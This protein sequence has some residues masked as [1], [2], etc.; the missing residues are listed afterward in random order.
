MSTST[1]PT[2]G[3]ISAAVKPFKPQ[4]ASIDSAYL[5]ESTTEVSEAKTVATKIDTASNSD[6]S[7]SE[8][9]GDVVKA[10]TTLREEVAKL[11]GDSLK[12]LAT[13]LEGT[14]ALTARVQGLESDNV[15]K[16]YQ[17]EQLIKANEMPRILGSDTAQNPFVIYVTYR[18]LYPGLLQIISQRLIMH[19]SR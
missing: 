18:K 4:V 11:R 8:S 6:N 12:A 5:V 17:I 7:E 2:K 3:K 13:L 9:Y 10:L 14:L 1:P 15:E 16:A 19:T